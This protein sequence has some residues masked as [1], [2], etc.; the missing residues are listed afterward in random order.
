MIIEAA[1]RTTLSV[2]VTAYDVVGYHATSALASRD[3]EVYGFVPHKVL[4]DDTHELLVKAAVDVGMPAQATL[5]YR[6]WLEMRSVTF[7][8]SP[9]PALAHARSGFAGGQGLKNVK[10]IVAAIQRSSKFA[11]LVAEVQQQIDEI[12]SAGAVVY[13]INLSGL[14]SRLVQADDCADYLR[15]YFNPLFPVPKVSVV[16]P[17]RLIARLDL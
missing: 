15:V 11:S 14:G 12:E 8:K 13:A 7:T 2:D 17:D 5:G 9:Q 3:I 4:S 16:G 1:G 10:G 6:Q